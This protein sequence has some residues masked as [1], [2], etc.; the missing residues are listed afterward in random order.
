MPDDML[1]SQPLLHSLRF[2]IRYFTTFQ[3]PKDSFQIHPHLGFHKQSPNE[4]HLGSMFIHHLPIQSCLWS[5]F[6]MPLI[7]WDFLLRASASLTVDMKCAST[8]SREGQR[9]NSSAGNRCKMQIRYFFSGK[10]VNAS[11]LF[12]P[13]SHVGC[14]LSPIIQRLI[15]KTKVSG[16][17][18][19]K[20][21]NAD[22]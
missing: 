4:V 6:C 17:H 14:Q 22:N 7:T 3:K 19:L 9:I 21:E 20:F 1:K 18:I 15:N 8:T 12:K 13:L 11:Y 16:T 2:S 10:M 5:F